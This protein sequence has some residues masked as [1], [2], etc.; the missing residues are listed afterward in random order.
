MSL[1]YRIKDRF[2]IIQLVPQKEEWKNKTIC[3]S[4]HVLP[5]KNE[6]YKFSRQNSV[7]PKRIISTEYSV[8]HSLS[9]V[10]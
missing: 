1:D 10:F 3:P 9:V 5:I 7:D 2:L 8:I 4:S 6:Y